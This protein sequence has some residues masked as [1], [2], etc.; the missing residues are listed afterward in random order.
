MVFRCFLVV[1]FFLDV[2]FLPDTLDCVW[3]VVVVPVVELAEDWLLDM[4]V[5]LVVWV[6][7]E[8]V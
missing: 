5:V 3:V 1:C 6:P 4:P 7:V 2:I 8:E